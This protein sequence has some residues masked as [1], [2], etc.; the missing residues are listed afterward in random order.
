M[1]H[2]LMKYNLLLHLL[3]LNVNTNYIKIGI[4]AE[5]LC[6]IIRLE[7]INLL[8]TGTMVLIIINGIVLRK[9]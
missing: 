7:N 3:E 8:L 9:L 4:S 1:L 2:I 6:V 5:L